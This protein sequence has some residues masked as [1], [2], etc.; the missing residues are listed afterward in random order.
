MRAGADADDCAFPASILSILNRASD[1]KS[2][3]LRYR[4][5]Q[6]LFWLIW[7][8]RRSEILGRDTVEIRSRMADRFS[9]QLP[10]SS[11]GLLTR[12]AVCERCYSLAQSGNNTICSRFVARIRN[13][14]C[15]CQPQERL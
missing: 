10:Y 12:Y 3:E 6:L 11:A 7:K 2:R 1:P 4:I 15:G 9:S 5:N 14:V 8:P 13:V